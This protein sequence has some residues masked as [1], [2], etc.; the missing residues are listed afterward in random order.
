MGQISGKE[1]LSGGGAYGLREHSPLW[2]EIMVARVGFGGSDS[3]QLML[4][5]VQRL[6]PTFRVNLPTPANVLRQ[7]LTRLVS[8]ESNS[9]SI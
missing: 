4:S 2:R 9:Q 6:G 8:K 5:F 1:K 7:F 3:I